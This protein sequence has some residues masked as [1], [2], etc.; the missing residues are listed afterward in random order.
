[1][2][3][4]CIAVEDEPL[5]LE[6]LK[7]FIG[8][9]PQLELIAT[10]RNAQSALEF[11]WHNPVQLIFLD[12]RM[13]GVSGIEMIERMGVRPQVIFTTAYNEYAIRAF[14]L[15]ATDYLLKP[16]TFERFCQ[17]V[18]KAGEYIQWQQSATIAE[19]PQTDYIFVKSGYKLVKVMLKDVQYIEGMRDYQCIVTPDSKVLASLT[20]Q[21]LEK[22]LPKDFVRCQKSYIVAISKIESIEN[23]RIKIGSKYIPIGDTYKEA[24]YK[25]I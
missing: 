25:Q 21:E 15:A 16:Y 17:A 5:A 20:F 6:K 8:K 12:I 18:N 10:F 22:I 3:I 24:F 19:K 1:M 9:L 7:S 13:D 14:E 23:D 11:V 4:K 2:N